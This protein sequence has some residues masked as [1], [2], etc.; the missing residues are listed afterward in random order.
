VPI[1]EYKCNSC[2]EISEKLQDMNADTHSLC[3]ICNGK[4]E[5]IISSG[6]GLVFK[7]SGFYITDYKKKKSFQNKK[8]NSLK[9][10]KNNTKVKSEPKCDSSSVK[11]EKEVKSKDKTLVSKSK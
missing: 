2:G 10:S 7:G 11:K 9:E 6:V 1:Y 4:A 5:R 3:P 8:G